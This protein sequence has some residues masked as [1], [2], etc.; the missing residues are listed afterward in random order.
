[1]PG[2]HDYVCESIRVWVY[3][4]AIY[5]GDERERENGTGTFPLVP[6][7]PA[8]RGRVSTFVAFCGKTRIAKVEVGGDSTS[9][10]INYPTDAD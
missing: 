1:M 9:G 6:L 8:R 3:V 7:H 5:Y 10:T 2:R 4:R